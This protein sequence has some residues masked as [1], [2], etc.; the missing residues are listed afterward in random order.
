MGRAVF[1]KLIESFVGR[2]NT[3]HVALQDIDGDGFASADLFRKLVNVF[4]DLSR[5][6]TA[7]G[8]GFI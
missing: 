4:A 3:S 5:N 1:I 7:P 8:S 2:Q 6:S